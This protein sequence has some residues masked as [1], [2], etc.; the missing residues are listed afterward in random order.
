MNITLIRHTSVACEPT[1]C[2]G[3]TDVDV[4][5]SFAHEAEK[6]RQ[7]LAN[8]TFDAIYSSPLKR[9]T[10]LAEYCG[11][12]TPIIDNRL[13]ELNFGD[14]E[15]KPWNEI[16]DPHLNNWYADWINTRT[17]NGESFAEQVQRVEDF[18]NE[19]KTTGQ[20]QVLIFTHAG[21]IRS[22]AILLGLIEMHQAF[23]D[24][25]VEYGEINRFLL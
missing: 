16:N 8:R 3:Q 15:M 9:C 6:V 13:M 21:V 2:Y 23:S 14:W 12:K 4:A 11:Y 22:V 10:Q 25:N 20:Q 18:L 7:K 17:T 19:L 24:F 5:V 1:I